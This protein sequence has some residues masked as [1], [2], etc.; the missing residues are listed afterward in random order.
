MSRSSAD[1]ILCFSSAGG[2]TPGKDSE[3]GDCRRD[4][5]NDLPSSFRAV[6]LFG[7]RVCINEEGK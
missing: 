1:V 7:V 3:T 6:F 5:A 2:A 4:I